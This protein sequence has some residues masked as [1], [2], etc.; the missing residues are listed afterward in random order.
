[1]PPPPLPYS[2]STGITAGASEV[3]GY[4][5]SLREQGFC[6]VDRTIPPDELARV[7][8]SVLESRPKIRAQQLQ[9]PSWESWRGVWAVASSRRS[10]EYPVYTEPLMQL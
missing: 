2:L 7:R 3:T 10:L 5:R 9:A 1:M 8:E 6:V 4:L